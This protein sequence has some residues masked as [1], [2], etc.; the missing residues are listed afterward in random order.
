MFE[1]WRY[2][3]QKRKDVKAYRWI[4][5]QYRNEI[6]EARRAKKKAAEIRSIEERHRWELELA[7][8]EIEWA[9]SR[10]FAVSDDSNQK[11]TTDSHACTCPHLANIPG[12]R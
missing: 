7:Q 12:S 3:R 10:Q 9:A 8:D 4:D 11:R 2:E 6:S 5:Q 1:N